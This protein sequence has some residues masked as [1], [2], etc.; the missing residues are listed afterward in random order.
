MDLTE[1]TKYEWL[2]QLS[3]YRCLI[4]ADCLITVQLQLYK[5]ISG[6]KAANAPITFEET[7]IVMITPLI[8][9]T[10]L[11]ELSLCSQ[12]RLSEGSD[13]SLLNLESADIVETDVLERSGFWQ[14]GIAY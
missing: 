6:K 2:L 14:V 12:L 9:L 7:V 3:N 1:R 4:I 10:S 11:S 8:T 5:V 13:D